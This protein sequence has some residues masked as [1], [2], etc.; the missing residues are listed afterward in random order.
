M[1]KGPVFKFKTA[2]QRACPLNCSQYMYDKMSVNKLLCFFPEYDCGIT[3][4]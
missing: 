2:S 1:L 4:I 3:R